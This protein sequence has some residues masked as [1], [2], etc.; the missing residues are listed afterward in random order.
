[1]VYHQLCH[2]SGLRWVNLWKMNFFTN[3]N[4][5]MNFPKGLSSES[6]SFS[7]TSNWKVNLW[8]HYLWVNACDIC[9]YYEFKIPCYVQ[10]LS[11]MWVVVINHFYHFH[12]LVHRLKATKLGSIDVT[13]I[14]LIDLDALQ[15]PP[16][17]RPQPSPSV[18]PSS[19]PPSTSTSQPSSSTFSPSDLSK[20]NS[21][22]HQ[23][24]L[25][26]LNLDQ[27][28]FP[29]LSPLIQHSAQPIFFFFITISHNLP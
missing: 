10:T 11:P 4:W 28:S 24:T 9:R 18:G 16:L 6:L 17:R 22:I 25:V 19:V 29:L 21:H 20:V 1:M 27:P 12:V 8:V 7:L 5:K 3:S 2:L 13:S 15:S 14:K 26:P 23:S